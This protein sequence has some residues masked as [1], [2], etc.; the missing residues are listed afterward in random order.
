M[1][2]DGLKVYTCGIYIHIPCK[3]VSEKVGVG[4]PRLLLLVWSL[5]IVH[6]LIL[7]PTQRIADLSVS[8]KDFPKESSS[9]SARFLNDCKGRRQASPLMLGAET[10]ASTVAAWRKKSLFESSNKRIKEVKK[11][12]PCQLKGPPEDRDWIMMT[13]SHVLIL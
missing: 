1:P 4:I 2:V 8:V 12:W 6:H 11:T 3:Q 13:I 9:S 10:K 5:L 7:K